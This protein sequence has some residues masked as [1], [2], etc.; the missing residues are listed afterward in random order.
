M[1]TSKT[2]KEPILNYFTCTL[3]QAAQLSPSTFS[4]ANKLID[5]QAE[6][7]GEDLACGFITPRNGDQEWGCDLLSTCSRDTQKHHL[8]IPAAYEDLRKASIAAAAELGPVIT[9]GS[10]TCVAFLCASSSDFL[11]TWLGLMRA[12][13]SILLIA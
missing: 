9:N 8:L 13:F 5:K 11:F 12:G 1:F 2:S 6:A 4:T 10:V 7:H 3:G